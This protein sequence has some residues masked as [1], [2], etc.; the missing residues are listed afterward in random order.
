MDYKT[1]LA[2]FQARR[3]KVL[4]YLASGKTQ[5]EAAIK[6]KVSRQRINQIVSPAKH[7]ARKATRAAIIRGKIPNPGK[8][9]CSDC[10]KIATEYDHRDY[11]KPLAVEPVCRTCNIRRGKGKNG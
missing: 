3:E 5:G 1:V 11:K 7:K 4:A 6:F 9:M 10:G 8:L 2:T